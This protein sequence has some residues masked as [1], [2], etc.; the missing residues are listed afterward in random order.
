MNTLQ[1]SAKFSWSRALPFEL[2]V[3]ICTYLS[4][5]AHYYQNSK[6]FKIIKILVRKPVVIYKNLNSHSLTNICVAMK[7]TESAHVDLTNSSKL[8]YLLNNFFDSY[9]YPKNLEYIKFLN[10]YDRIYSRFPEHATHIYVDDINL[11]D[12]TIFTRLRFLS[13]II[14]NTHPLT[15]YPET[16]KYLILSSAQ[17]MI[18]EITIPSHV[19]HLKL[20]LDVRILHVHNNITHLIIQRV[21]NLNMPLN[22]EY[23]ECNM[24]LNG[25]I[26]HLTKLHTLLL[27]G[28]YERELPQSIVNL[29]VSSSEQV[30]AASKLKNLNNLIISNMRIIDKLKDMDDERIYYKFNCDRFSES[31]VKLKVVQD[32]TR[33]NLFEKIPKSL[34]FLQLTD[35]TLDDYSIFPNMVQLHLLNWDKSEAIPS[36]LTHLCMATDDSYCR[37]YSRFVCYDYGIVFTAIFL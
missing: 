33:T 30:E 18:T 16:L 36:S 28:Y 17:F 31:L 35:M 1:Y 29:L 23:L 21:N 5:D 13:N 6:L 11:Y 27:R 2:L 20:K 37:L 19:T 34:K 3:N 4:H 25:N 32:L 9:I 22:L 7:N 26:S 8:K 14:T 10:A 24:H 15:T 12:Y